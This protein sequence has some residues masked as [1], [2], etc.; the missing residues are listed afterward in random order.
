MVVVVAM[1]VLALAGA[2]LLAASG[3]EDAAR[4]RVVAAGAAREA[5]LAALE[6]EYARLEV[7]FLEWR[8]RE[9]AAE[10]RLDAAIVA[11]A[12]AENAAFEAARAAA[13]Q[14]RRDARSLR[15]AQIDALAARLLELLAAR[16][17]AAGELREPLAE[18]VARE[19]AGR[20]ADDLAAR[21]APVL[22][23][24]LGEPQRFE[25]LWNARLYDRVPAAREWRERYDE[26][27]AAG[28]ELDRILHP[29]SYLPGGTKT[30]PGMVYVAGGSYSLGP[31]I[32]IERKRRR[33]TVRPFMIDRCEVSNADY[34]A[35]LD[36]LPPEQREA[37]TPRHWIADATGRL[38]PPPELLD[39]PVTYVTWRDADAF[40]RA[41]G[42]RLPTEDEWEAACRGKDGQLYPWGEQWTEGRANDAKAGVGTTVA[43]KRF[44]E[45]ASPF[46]VL[47]MS[48]NVEEWTASG[49]DG[50]TLTELGSNIL[51]V[52][53]RGGH[54]RS[55]PEYASGAFRWVAPGGSTREPH[56]GFRCAADLP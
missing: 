31:N 43:V 50:T 11:L 16:G 25:L 2:A 20:P 28:V 14:E 30:R 19:L 15:R 6:T 36:T 22:E 52:V 12:A 29:E 7:A 39:H 24:W 27:V 5:A 46:K 38:V 44:E 45:G 53:V 42:K 1:R 18:F 48:G 26:H 40:A 35:F 55:P 33:V 21:L 23:E 54:F 41:A 4:Q 47:Q 10:T 51:A 34:L 37:R 32:G 56:L 3:D 8:G 9:R 13:P 17:L 49:E